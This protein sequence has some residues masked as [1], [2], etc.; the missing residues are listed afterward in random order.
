MVV[1]SIDW[2]YTTDRLPRSIRPTLRCG[3]R[4]E[5]RNLGRARRELPFRVLLSLR[6]IGPFLCWENGPHP[7]CLHCERYLRPD[8]V[9][10]G[11]FGGRRASLAWSGIGFPHFVLKLDA[12]HRPVDYGFEF[13]GIFYF[14]A[15]G[16][17]AFRLFG[18][19]PCGPAIAFVGAAH[20][21]DFHEEG[22]RSEEHTS[23]LQSLRHLVCRLL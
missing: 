19:H 1:N 12:F 8:G 17:A 2:R 18:A 15:F 3:W 20:L 21:V 14:A 4:Y 10:D 11:I 6:S 7:R 9:G 5:K 22:F 16:Q 13:A 23:E